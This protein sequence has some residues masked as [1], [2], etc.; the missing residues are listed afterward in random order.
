MKSNSAVRPVL[1]LAP[2]L[3]FACTLS[4][5]RPVVSTPATST[6]SVKPGVSP[7]A[8][9]SPNPTGEAPTAVIPTAGI[10]PSS[11][12]NGS[13]FCSSEAPRTVISK[14]RSAIMNADGE[15]LASLVSPTHGMDARL[16]RDGRVV[17]Y[18]AAHAAA[19]FQ[20]TFSLN[21]GNA[22]GSGLPAVGSF[23]QLIVPDLLDVLEREYDLGCNQILVGGTTYTA[24][25]PYP[26]IDF[27]SLYFPGTEAFGQMDWH[28]WLL[29]MQDAG[30]TP[31]LVAIMQ[32][33]WEP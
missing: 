13:G 4:L 8:P 5:F 26:G 21:W 19:L 12:A 2:L 29:G 17:N 11:A 1:V 16:F 15:L 32:F 9:P 20:S 33:K 7:T 6:P 25:W 30:G 24:L 3:L 31:R 18:D 22:P 27:Y 28:T 14:F 10:V 23:E